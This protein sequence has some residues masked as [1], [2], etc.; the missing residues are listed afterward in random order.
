LTSPFST[1]SFPELQVVRSDEETAVARVVACLLP[2]QNE[3]DGL[4][5]SP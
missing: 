4:W 2:L 3:L 1:G 5:D